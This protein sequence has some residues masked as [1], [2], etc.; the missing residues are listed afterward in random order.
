M[1]D[2]YDEL[3]KLCGFEDH[4]IEKERPRIEKAFQRLELG[5]D[6]IK[7][8]ENWV[9]QNHDVE[10]MGV[11]KLLW[12][13]LEEL[14]DLVL[15]KDEGKKLLYYGFPTIAGPASAIAA[16]SEYVYSACPDVVLCYT[17]GQ[18]F[19]KLSP[20]LEAGEENGLPP[21]H[22]LCSLQQ[23]RVGGMSKGII[24]VPDMVITSSYNCDM[25]SKTDE[26]LHQ[27]YG[28]PAIYVDGS[29]DS[30]WGEFPDFLPERAIYLGGQLERVF[31]EAKELL[32]IEVT[33]EVRSEG[34]SRNRELAGALRELVELMQR[35]DP[36]PISIV[37]VEVARRL[38]SGSANRR[39][40]TEGPGI[41]AT[42]NRE[43]KERID[44]GV[45]VVEKGAPKVMILMAH[46][47]D[48][49]TMHMMEDCGLSIPTTLHTV[50]ASRI[51]KSTPFISGEILAKE[52]LE[53]GP[54]HSAFGEI[55]QAAEAARLFNTDGIIWNYLYNCRPFALTSHLIRQFVEK[56]TEIPVLS[57]EMDLYDSRSYSAAALR[58]RVE[59]FAEMLRVRK[60]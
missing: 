34:A 40:L 19:N 59:T 1:A 49:S 2:Y 17:M 25:G 5:P 58:T 12:I 11:R 24:P 20:I 10:L 18:I 50:L 16:A 44:R 15:A 22:S 13:W 55:K 56:E 51:F 23:I 42:L 21:G 45:G 26:L 54:F 37:D 39:F 35:A 6:D 33:S 36:Q 38:T 32:G 28:H 8:A 53:R 60:V 48:P 29:M 57:L 30:R 43:V 14:I 31:D 3:L 47:S 52:Q 7:T 27:K 4:E 46:F 41:I 9:R